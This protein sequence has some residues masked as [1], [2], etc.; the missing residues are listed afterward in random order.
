[1]YAR[2]VNSVE[3]G[4]ATINLIASHAGVLLFLICGN[5]EYIY[6][7]RNGQEFFLYTS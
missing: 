1:M 7:R 6:P 4:G 2:S 5:K 3:V